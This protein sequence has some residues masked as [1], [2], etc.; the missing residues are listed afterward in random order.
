M[1]TVILFSKFPA[2]PQED[3]PITHNIQQALQ[4]ISLELT[5]L[6]DDRITPAR[7]HVE[8]LFAELERVQGLENAV[9]ESRFAEMSLQASLQDINRKR[10]EKGLPPLGAG[11]A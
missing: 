4:A 2:R 11:H 5:N 10:R 1:Q 6:P 7:R 9:L 3:G 8:A